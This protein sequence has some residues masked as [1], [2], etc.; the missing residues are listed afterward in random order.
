MPAELI[1]NQ[2][3]ALAD[4]Y[5]FLLAEGDITRANL[6]TKLIAAQGVMEDGVE[7]NAVAFEGGNTQGVVMYPK[8][9]V[10]AAALQILR[11]TADDNPLA[12]AVGSAV[13]ADFSACRIET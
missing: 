8:E 12:G 9:V 7:V 2:T 6:K 13:H 4:T 10:M 3:A 11:E 5:R 1:A